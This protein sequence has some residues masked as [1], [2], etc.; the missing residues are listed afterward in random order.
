MTGED[1]KKMRHMEAG[2]ARQLGSEANRRYLRDLP[3]FRHDPAMP[4]RFGDLLERIRQ[5]EQRQRD[6]TPRE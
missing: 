2:L 4:E 1:T 6:G 5:A 3:I